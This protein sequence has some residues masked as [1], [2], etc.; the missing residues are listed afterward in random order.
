MPSVRRLHRFCFSLALLAAARLHAADD[1]RFETLSGLAG[2]R[3]SDNV[4]GAL[5][6]LPP[7]LRANYTLVFASRSLQGATPY[8]PRAILFGS[9]ARLIVTFNGDAAERGYDVLETMQFDDR[10]NT[11][12]FRELSFPSGLGAVASED[13]P[14]RCAAC[15]GRPARPIWD[16]LPTWPGVYGERYRAGLSK[17]ESAGMRAFLARQAS[18][19]RYGQLIGAQR[20][21]D[22]ETY[23]AGAATRYDGD[24]FEPPNARLSVLL[25]TLNVRSIVSDLSN[26]PAFAPHRYV[27]LAAAGGDCGS[28]S[29][30]FPDSM[31]S[32]TDGAMR[33]FEKASEAAGALQ[34]TAKRN[35]RASIAEGYQS[36]VAVN[37]PVR[38]RFIAERLVGMPRQRWNLALEAETFD[39]ASPDG[40]LS[41]Q[42]LLFEK[43]ASAEPE[44]RDL[45]SFRSFTAADAYCAELRRRSRRDLAAYYRAIGSDAL[46]RVSAAPAAAA[47]GR[48]APPGLI[49][50]CIACH[51]GEVGPALPFA[52]PA[53]LGPRLTTGE[54][55]HGRL[56]D[57]ILYRLSPQAAAGRMPRDV[58]PTPAEQHDLEEYFVRLAV[59]QAQALDQARAP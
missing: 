7:E 34:R 39:F 37:D 36:G 10:T 41:L 40:A 53:A 27:M 48:A 58:N 3:H 14:A 45:R 52:D 17:P 15:H 57:E 9:D 35:R 6:L 47:D 42:Q 28:L 11:F 49:Q 30:F 8:A 32:A 55:P 5:M 20:L 44:L 24:K 12:H 4:Q 26:Q 29:A 18:D 2:A 21:G 46:Q 22:R 54:Y 19:P 31:R 59:H 56:L 33:A 25:A 16:A 50:H 23:V 43:I 13:N 38:L 51:D 1:F